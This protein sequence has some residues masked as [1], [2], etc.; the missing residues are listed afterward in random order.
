MNEQ[1]KKKDLKTILKTF[2]TG[3]V[4]AAVQQVRE[5]TTRNADSPFNHNLQSLP[6]FRRLVIRF[7]N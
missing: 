2:L 7:E 4:I 1:K 6:N 3:A 5:S